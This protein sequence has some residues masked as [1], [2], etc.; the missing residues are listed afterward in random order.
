MSTVDTHVFICRL[1]E[2]LT[3]S[4]SSRDVDLTNFKMLLKYDGAAHPETSGRRLASHKPSPHTHSHLCR[5]RTHITHIHKT[6]CPSLTSLCA[7]T[8]TRIQKHK[9][10]LTHTCRQFDVEKTDTKFGELMAECASERADDIY[11]FSYGYVYVLLHSFVSY[12]WP[13]MRSVDHGHLSGVTFALNH[14]ISY[15]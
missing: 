6:H 10:T 13:Q 8:Q 7:H 11:E 5:M 14:T 9:P 12:V 2:G 15:E 1:Q 4:S 3:R